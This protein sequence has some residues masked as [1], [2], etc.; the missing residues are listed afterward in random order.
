MTNTE[1]TQIAGKVVREYREHDNDLKR[2]KSIARVIRDMANEYAATPSDEQEEI[3]RLR[4]EIERLNSELIK[5]DR[6]TTKRVLRNIELVRENY[7][8]RGHECTCGR[9]A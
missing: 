3:A 9:D 1:A 7:K 2:M 6:G 5:Q 4:A 8:L